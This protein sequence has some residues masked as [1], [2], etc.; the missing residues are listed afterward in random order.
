M[1]GHVGHLDG[2]AQVR[3]VGAVFADRLV[4]GDAR[5]STG[6]GLRRPTDRSELLEDPG[7]HRLHG[8]KYIVLL[9]EAHLD[10]E[11]VELARQPIGARVLVAEAGRDL[12]IAVEARHHQE[13]LVLLRRLRQR[14]ELAGMDA[15]RHQEV[16]RALGR[17]RGQNRRRELE[18]ARLHHALADRGRDRQA[19]HDVLV[20]RLAPEIEEAVLQA[21][22][23]RVV[24]L[25]EHRDRQLLCRGEHLDLGREQ[26]DLA[27]RQFRVDSALGA[28]A[29]LAVDAHHP[30]GAHGLGGLERGAVGIGHD[31]RDAVVVAQ[32]DEQQPA[33]VA[34][35]VH[36]ARQPHRLADVGTAQRAA[37]VRAVAVQGAPCAGWR[38]RSAPRLLFRLLVRHLHR[39]LPTQVAEK[40]HGVIG[41]SRV[42]TLIHARS[43]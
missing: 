18:E 40:A 30:L 35:A 21:Q 32:I 13:L 33:V 10:V 5:P 8:G 29:H 28:R 41:L 1:L 23:F 4:V 31:L 24:G 9:D 26:L 16:A 39:P 15:R 17:G 11:L 27:G 25:A 19:L 34:H 3:L 2:V 22:I 14:V 12:E 7:D 43:G 6:D 42:A 36:P 37:G 38:G 20:Q